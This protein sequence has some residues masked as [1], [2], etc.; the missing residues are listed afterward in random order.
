MRRHLAFAK[1]RR[2][3]G[4]VVRFW[5]CAFFE[6]GNKKSPATFPEGEERLGY[7]TAFVG[8][9]GPVPFLWKLA[10]SKRAQAKNCPKGGVL[11]GSN[12]AGLLECLFG[13]C[14]LTAQFLPPKRS[15]NTLDA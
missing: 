10:G 7:Y 9:V 1:H 5:D 15:E 14:R 3:G 13:I 4:L 6:S 2:L 12:P 8:L 11:R